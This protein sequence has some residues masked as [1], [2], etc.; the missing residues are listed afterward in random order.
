MAA[1]VV[2]NGQCT[3]ASLELINGTAADKHIKQQLSILKHMERAELLLAADTAYIEFGAGRGGLSERIRCALRA[4]SNVQFVLVDKATCRRKADGA[5]RSSGL[6]CYHRLL[7]DIVDLDLQALDLL[8][9]VEHVVGIAKHLCGVATDFALRCLV[10]GPKLRG[11]VIAL[12]CHHRV[13]WSHLTGSDYLESLGFNEDDFKLLSHMTSWAVCGVRGADECTPHK[14]Q[15]IGLMCKRLIDFA[16]MNYV[17]KCGLNAQLVY[18][19][20]REVTLENVL[21]I[22]H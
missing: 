17:R 15:D 21:L 1:N 16:R 11:A 7:M 18:Y 4:P 3:H 6:N 9:G 8:S 20:S 5:L 13:Q 22:V 10:N 2:M 12:C 19:V 14:N